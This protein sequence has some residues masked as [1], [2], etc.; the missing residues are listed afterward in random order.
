M[1]DT[2]PFIV[3]FTREKDVCHR[4]KILIKKG[5]QIKGAKRSSG[6]LKMGVMNQVNSSMIYF[7]VH[8]FSTFITAVFSVF[9]C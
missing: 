4:C 9:L 2:L 1:A 8:L 3:N 6:A 7:E 5:V